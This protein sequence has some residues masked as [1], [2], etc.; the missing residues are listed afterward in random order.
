MSKVKRPR[1]ED[2]A[3]ISESPK[4][5][6]NPATTIGRN[7]SSA[8]NP[9][10]A[11]NSLPVGIS[12]KQ[13]LTFHSTVGSLSAGKHVSVSA[14][15]ASHESP[16]SVSEWQTLP[17][18]AHQRSIINAVKT[19]DLVILAGD[20]GC[21]KTTGIGHLLLKNHLKRYGKPPKICI[22]QPR[23]VAAIALA[24]RVAKVVE[25]DQQI[26][27]LYDVAHQKNPRIKK[28]NWNVGGIVG[29]RVRHDDK[30]SSQ[31]AISFV[32]DG[33]LIREVIMHSNG[34]RD[35]QSKERSKQNETMED[36]SI[37][38]NIKYD[39]I[40]IDEAHERSIRIDLL[41]G[42][43]RLVLASGMGKFKVVIMSATMDIDTLHKFFRGPRNVGPPNVGPPNV[44]PPNVGPPNEGPPNE[45]LV[46]CDNSSSRQPNESHLSSRI[47]MD[48][49]AIPGRT[50]PV[51]AL[52]ATHAFEDIVSACV[53]SAIRIITETDEGDILI[54]LPGTEDINSVCQGIEKGIEELRDCQLA[55]K[56]IERAIVGLSQNREDY[57][58]L[59]EAEDPSECLQQLYGGSNRTQ[60][61][62]QTTMQIKRFLEESPISVSAASVSCQ[63]RRGDDYTA[64]F[65]LAESI[66]VLPLHASLTGEQQS[67]VF[68]LSPPGGRK[69]IVAT[70]IA[71]T[72][73]TLPQVRYVIDSG[74][75]KQR[76]GDTLRVEPVSQAM[77]LQRTGRA[78][79]VAAGM[80]LRLFTEDSF[81]KLEAQSAPEIQRSHLEDYV[82]W[83]KACDMVQV[84]RNNGDGDT[85]NANGINANGIN[86]NG[87]NG[88]GTNDNDANGNHYGALQRLLGAQDVRDLV[89]KFPVPSPPAVSEVDRSIN[90]LKTI[91]ALD[92]SCS[93]L[94][95]KGYLISK[96]P[97]SVMWANCLVDTLFN[98]PECLGIM[99][100]IVAMCSSEYNWF[101]KTTE[102]DFRVVVARQAI[103]DPVSDHIG[104]LS[105]YWNWSKAFDK[106]AFCKLVRVDERLLRRT[107][108][109]VDQLR[110]IILKDADFGCQHHIVDLMER[111]ASGIINH[112][113][114][115]Q[116]ASR[117]LL[118]SLPM[119]IAVKRD[120]VQDNKEFAEVTY[121]NSITKEKLFIHPSS[122][123]FLFNTKRPE[124]LVYSSVVET[125]KAYMRDVTAISPEIAAEVHSVINHPKPSP[126]RR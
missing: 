45:R 99:I 15:K 25:S 89:M 114:I 116:R 3:W 22:T 50:F 51:T 108:M 9:S 24:Q 92:K 73:V 95:R 77:A 70:N 62:E 76:R 1:N 91:G 4:K 80:A 20:T 117:C 49:V 105:L 119:N 118:R 60:F 107:S 32:T 8:R 104:W 61:G 97:L 72:S 88:N 86:A 44:G 48:F 96:L 65:H 74:L 78:G 85:A 87:I 93:H 112:E 36:I 120:V 122:S 57:R 42:Y 13:R 35:T 6:R 115:V 39:Y 101:D 63:T 98:D 125:S 113:E 5:S 2:A 124:F 54:F 10:I 43:I 12:S 81:D 69:I 121:V 23:R 94:S 40:V 17:V 79:R 100:I 102:H 27:Q 34:M 31:T 38:K 26:S 123:M 30:V 106:R 111:K 14:T 11:G 66:V 19:N 18:F 28:P 110:N 29:Y 84:P 83:L 64:K 126:H 16:V 67:R 58:K 82:L 90:T 37:S 75:V 53:A 7:P 56:S 71:E 52:F 21:G 47:R 103:M 59:L 68:H 109:T 33:L 46:K 55:Y 41:L